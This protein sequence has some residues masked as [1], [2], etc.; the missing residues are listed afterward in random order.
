MPEK[1]CNLYYSHDRKLPNGIDENML[2]YGQMDVDTCKGDSGGPIQ[3]AV[4]NRTCPL[5]KSTSSYIIVGI[6][7]YGWSICGSNVPGIYIRVSSFYDWIEQIVN[8]V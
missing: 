2:C 7:S 4:T 8:I 5:T 3:I 1:I 6:T